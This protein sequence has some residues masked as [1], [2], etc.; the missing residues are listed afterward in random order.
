MQETEVD[1]TIEDPYITIEDHKERF[2]D[3]IPCCLINPSKSSIGKTSKVVLNKI[4]NHIQ[5]ETFA[6]Q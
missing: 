4:N 3:K 2:H 6:N 1:I 5:K